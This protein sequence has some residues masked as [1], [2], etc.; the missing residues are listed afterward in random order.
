MNQQTQEVNV[1]GSPYFNIF[2]E[3]HLGPFTNKDLTLLLER[4]NERFDSSD[5]NYITKASGYH[6]Y[7]AQAAA[8]TL[9]DVGEQNIVGLPRYIAAGEALQ[10]QTR[11]HFA[12]T[13]RSWTNETRKAMT[14]VALTQI[15][16]LLEDRN[17]KVNRLT[18]DLNDYYPELKMLV[19]NGMLTQ[20]E[21]GEWSV[22]QGAFLWWL[23]DELRRN[24]RD[25]TE[26]NVWLQAQEIDGLF[27]NE[28]KQYLGQAVGNCLTTMKQGTPIL[29]EA[30]I[31]NIS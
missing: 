4:S 8:S 17:F 19:D 16:R 15:P 29:I 5:H 1:Y 7:L 27:T 6:P 10:R 9:W 14:A 24:V 13:W 11:S 3:I 22:A 12:D 28:K 18:M 25:Q 2:T 31:S 26:F 21:Q 30:F 20:N 23:A